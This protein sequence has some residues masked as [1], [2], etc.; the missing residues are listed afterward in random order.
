MLEILF[1]SRTRVKLLKIFLSQPGKYFFVREL[2]RLTEEKINS[3]RRELDNLSD[4]GLIRTEDKIK[5]DEE[6]D[7]KQK[8]KYYTVNTGFVIYEELKSLFIK[9]KL[10]LE[11][12]LA[13]DIDAVGKISFLM[14]SG[15]FVDN[16]KGK[17]D[18]LIVGEVNKI[19]LK[20]LVSK[21][22]KNFDQPI[23]YTIMDEKEFKY[24]NQIT[25]KFLFEILDGKKVVIIDR[26]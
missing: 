9:S 3:V 13:K 24:R 16:P 5:L 20:T 17:V 1:G 7:T 10:L 18:M 19:K 4:F 15:I 14:L 2:S 25:D 26:L 6:T 11:K 23:R 22:E 12:T 8:K 21:I